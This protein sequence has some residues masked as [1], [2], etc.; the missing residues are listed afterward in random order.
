MALKAKS[1]IVCT[2]RI[3]LVS[4]AIFLASPASPR[5]SSVFDRILVI[6]HYK[7]IHPIPDIP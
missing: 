5:V 3:L 2:F 4:S 1:L 7:R 6:D